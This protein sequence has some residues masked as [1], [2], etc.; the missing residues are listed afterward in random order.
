MSS[1]KGMRI[2]DVF[3]INDKQLEL[4]IQNINRD[5]N[6]T[7]QD[8]VVVGGGGGLLSG[9]SVI[10]GGWNNITEVYLNLDG[11]GSIYVLNSVHIHLFPLTE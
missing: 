5:T 6:T 11:N 9:A 2:N 8:I 10:Q 4:E 1:V 3:P 7:N